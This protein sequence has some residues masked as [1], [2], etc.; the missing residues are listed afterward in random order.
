MNCKTIILIML[1]LIPTIQAGTEYTKT[2]ISF[3]ITESIEITVTLLGNA[4]VTSTTGAG[5]SLAH[6]IEWNLTSPYSG[7]RFWSNATV[8][9]GGTTQT[10]SSPILQIDNTGNRNLNI[11]I[12]TSSSIDSCMKL[13]ANTSSQGTN[14][15]LTDSTNIG[16]GSMWTVDPSFQTSDPAISI[17]M[18]MNFSS[19]TYDKTGNVK[20]F[21][22]AYST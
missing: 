21:I 15:T 1:I 19:C 13:Y 10:M 16:N 4:A 8:G 14:Q 17:Y 7:S 22:N 18:Y 12:N 20:L 9:G 3:E 11:T 2:I 6:N 5:S